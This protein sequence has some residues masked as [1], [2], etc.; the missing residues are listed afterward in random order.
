MSERISRSPPYY[1]GEA[2][3]VA[4]DLYEKL[5]WV[6][7]MCERFITFI[8]GCTVPQFMKLRDA[9]HD[10]EPVGRAFNVWILGM[11]EDNLNEKDAVTELQRNIAVLEH[12]SSIHL[13]DNLEGYSQ[14]LPMKVQIMQSHLDTTVSIVLNMRLAVLENIKPT[15]DEEE[16]ASGFLK[17][18]EGMISNGRHTKVFITKILRALQNHQK[19]YLTLKLETRPAF[20]ECLDLTGKIAKYIRVLGMGVAGFLAPNE[21]ENKTFIKLQNVMYKTTEA[22][23]TMM[24]S[25]F[26]GAISKDLKTLGGLLGDLAAQAGD[27]DMTAEC[28]CSFHLFDWGVRLISLV[29]KLNLE[30]RHGLLALR[31]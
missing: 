12:L 5:T 1:Q 18:A 25:D 29:G 15:F 14:E 2:L 21:E 10:I 13:Q 31:S 19:R 23:M 4:C 28:K 20:Q 3:V 6:S 7:N 22:E 26:F 24:E 8:Q 30:R 11:K 27:L 16:L 17:A 9:V